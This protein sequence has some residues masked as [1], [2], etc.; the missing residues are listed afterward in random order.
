MTMINWDRV[1][2]L[3]H[4]V[5]EEDF[6]EVVAI[7]LE[8]VDAV[9]SRMHPGAEP[10]SLREDLHFLK[11]SALN[12]GFRAL[13]ALCEDLGPAA[14]PATPAHLDDLRRVYAL[15]KAEFLDRAGV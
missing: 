6:A 4:E 9:L 5:G 7:F 10:A 1:N 15:S 8:E 13:G 2:E 3:R 12:L 11:G 14:R